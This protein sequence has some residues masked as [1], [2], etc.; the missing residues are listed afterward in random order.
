MLQQ[1][2]SILEFDKTVRLIWE[3]LQG[4][5]ENLF[6]NANENQTHDPEYKKKDHFIDY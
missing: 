4:Q 6:K 5:A 3:H 2:Q 1:I